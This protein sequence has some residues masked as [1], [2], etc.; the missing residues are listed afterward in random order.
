MRIENSHFFSVSVSQR[1]SSLSDLF[2]SHL[3]VADDMFKSSIASYTKFMFKREFKG[4]L[5]LFSTIARIRKDVGD[6]DVPIHLPRAS[7]MRSL[8]KEASAE[9]LAEK[10]K[11]VRGRMEKHTTADSQCL[12][13]LWGEF[14]RQLCE[15]YRSYEKVASLIYQVKPDVGRDELQ[16]I[17]RV[18]GGDQ[19]Q[20]RRSGTKE[21]KER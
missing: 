14:G 11:V 16:R 10:V 12:A 2:T 4:L 7:F 8:S 9:A 6:A 5:Q 1:T 18:A 21:A 15:D 19:T 13:K 20:R 3:A 17:L